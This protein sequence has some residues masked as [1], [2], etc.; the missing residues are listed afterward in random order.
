MVCKDIID[1]SAE[2]AFSSTTTERYSYPSRLAVH[3]CIYIYVNISDSKDLQGHLFLVTVSSLALS[4][5][6]LFVMHC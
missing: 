3:T 6:N 4:N 5:A 1:H 2:I